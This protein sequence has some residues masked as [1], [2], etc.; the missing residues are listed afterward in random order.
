ML[1]RAAVSVWSAPRLVPWFDGEVGSELDGS[2]AFYTYR[3]PFMHQA[4]LSHKKAGGRRVETPESLTPLHHPQNIVFKN[5]IF[6][7]VKRVVA[8]DFWGG[9]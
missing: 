1:P 7:D 2:G 6:T 3:T 9:F 4:A 5:Q 8:K